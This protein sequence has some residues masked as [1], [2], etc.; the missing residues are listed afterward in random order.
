VKSLTGKV[1]PIESVKPTL[2]RKVGYVEE[3]VSYACKSST[4][5]NKRGHGKKRGKTERLKENSGCMNPFILQT[6]RY[7]PLHHRLYI[8][9]K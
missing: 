6:R 1:T 9:L 5:G 2:K 4:N 3:E 8:N 7:L